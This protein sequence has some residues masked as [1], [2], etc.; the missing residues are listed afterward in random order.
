[1]GSNNLKPDTSAPIQGTT[2]EEEGKT[3]EKL[4][5][6]KQTVITWSEVLCLIVKCSGW[7]PAGAMDEGKADTV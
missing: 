6:A 2:R 5:E 1:M 7:E 3:N 4:Q